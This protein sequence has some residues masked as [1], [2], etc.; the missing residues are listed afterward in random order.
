MTI[1]HRDLQS[2][3]FLYMGSVD[4]GTLGDQYE[5]LIVFD[6]GIK[7]RNGIEHGDVTT[8]GQVNGKVGVFGSDIGNI[9]LISINGGPVTAKFN[10]GSTVRTKV[11]GFV[12]NGSE[13][14]D[15]NGLVDKQKIGR[16][17]LFGEPV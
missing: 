17:F 7:I 13:L 3:Q 12:N 4:N 6:H 8:I 11:K 15:L 1:V 14:C 16:P 5:M 9:I 2:A 10:R